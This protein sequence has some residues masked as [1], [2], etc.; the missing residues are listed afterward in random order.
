MSYEQEIQMVRAQHGDLE[1]IRKTLGLSRRK[2]CEYLLVDPSAWTRW[3]NSG[4][5]QA[6]PHVYRTL[7]LLIEKTKT[8]PDFLQQQKGANPISKI[9]WQEEFTGLSLELKQDMQESLIS[10][11]ENLKK[12]VSHK[13][14]LTLGWKLLLLINIVLVLYVLFR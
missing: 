13:E 2:I 8:E 11:Y 7:A 14:E 6:P 5:D 3:V 12:Q 9:K 1:T 4:T 10:Q